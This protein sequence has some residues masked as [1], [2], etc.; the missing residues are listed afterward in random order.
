MWPLETFIACNPLQ[1]FEGQMF[2]EA[3]AQGGFGDQRAERN[4]Q[5]EEVNLQ[6]IK[7]C[8]SFFDAGQ[9]SI[10]MPYRERGFYYG[11]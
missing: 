8:G 9:S 11:F 10:E 7:W 6:M 1:G 2:E 4:P 5:L 3:L